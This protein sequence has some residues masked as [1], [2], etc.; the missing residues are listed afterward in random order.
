MNGKMPTIER[1]SVTGGLTGSS[2]YAWACFLR[3]EADMIGDA[4]GY[5]VFSAISETLKPSD[6]KPSVAGFYSKDLEEA[7]EAWTT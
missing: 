1:D 4:V 2:A 7:I 3:D 6:G 5:S